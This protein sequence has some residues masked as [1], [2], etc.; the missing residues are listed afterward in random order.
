MACDPLD[1]VRTLTP[2]V[3]ILDYL[4]PDMT[5][6]EFLQ[7]LNEIVGFSIMVSG[8]GNEDVAVEGLKLGI[9]DYQIRDKINQDNLT[10][11]LNNALTHANLSRRIQ[12]QKE[13][14]ENFV[15]RATYGPLF[16]K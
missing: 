12:D 8:Q 15:S 7:E 14:L 10:R 6:I 16:L 5:G 4:L 11:S 9:K 13:E 2:D 1:T 3:I